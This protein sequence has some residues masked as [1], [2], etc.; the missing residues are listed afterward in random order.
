MN[1]SVRDENGL[2]KRERAILKYIQKE[3][4]IKDRKS[5]V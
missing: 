3:I 4:S 2:N 5:V 1:K